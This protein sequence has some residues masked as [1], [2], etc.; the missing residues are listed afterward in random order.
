VAGTACA[1]AGMEAKLKPAASV[2][3]TIRPYPV[4]EIITLP[5]TSVVKMRAYRCEIVAKAG[6]GAS[7]CRLSPA[8]TISN[9]DAISVQD[10][11]LGR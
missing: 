9:Q 3:S 4:L 6:K 2:S 5:A 11:I 1:F 8:M 10:A 7:V